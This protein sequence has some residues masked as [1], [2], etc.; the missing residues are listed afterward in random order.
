MKINLDFKEKL[1]YYKI[2]LIFIFI[3]VC[4]LTSEIENFNFEIR[5]IGTLGKIG[6]AV[7]TIGM[8][9]LIY[10]HRNLYYLKSQFKIEKTEFKN[11]L[12]KTAEENEWEINEINSYYYIL[13][14]N[15]YDKF[16]RNDFLKK[17][18][19]E[20]IYVKIDNPLIYYKSVNDFDSDLAIRISSGE[21][22][23][24]EKLIRNIL[25]PAANNV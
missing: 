22:K 6:I 1:K 21:N 4:C 8:L 16:E 15:R 19:C 13:K 5:E 12:L 20:K 7:I 18:Y 11:R 24:N 2:T 14:T 10:L 3:G 23:L 17:N 25:M 9:N